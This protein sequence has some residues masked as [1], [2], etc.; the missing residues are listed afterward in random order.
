[1]SRQ[2][3]HATE[4]VRR[5]RALRARPPASDGMLKRYQCANIDIVSQTNRKGGTARS[6]RY[7][8]SGR[9]PNVEYQRTFVRTF[10][11]EPRSSSS[12]NLATGTLPLLARFAGVLLTSRSDPREEGTMAKKIS[13]LVERKAWLLTNGPASFD[14]DSKESGDKKQEDNFIRQRL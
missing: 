12:G 6:V 4:A 9:D 7:R 11:A 5:A 3:Q 8:H 2:P 10:E 13:R 14:N 1:M